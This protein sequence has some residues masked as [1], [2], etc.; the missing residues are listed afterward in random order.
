[1]TVEK[2]LLADVSAL[3]FPLME[4][5]REVDANATL[6]EVVKSNELRLWEG[7]P[8]LLMHSAE[9]GLFD[10]MAVKKYLPLTE[11][12]ET[13][14]QLL[15][16][17]LVLYKTLDLKFSWTAKLYHN[18]TFND[19]DKTFQEKLGYFKTK[20]VFRFDNATLSAQRLK[21]TFKNYFLQ[22]PDT[23]KDVQAQKEN[24]KLEYALSQVFSPK[25]KEL[26]LKKV[27]GEQLTKTEREYYSRSVRKKVMALTNEELH[28]LAKNL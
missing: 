21:N 1:M 12:Q 18:L 20:G 16:M 3:G 19:M 14:N 22:S 4:T 27:R 13:L 6:A 24:F 10:Y 15:L 5:G 28:Q 2:N 25:Q 9:N 11:Q 7:F 17:A 26:F 23:L 8:V